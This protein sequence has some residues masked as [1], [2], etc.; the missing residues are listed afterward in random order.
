MQEKLIIYLDAADVL[1]P[2]WALLGADNQVLASAVHDDA[3]NVSKH[4]I[5][6]E[7]WVLIPA[8]DV[9]LLTAQLPKM[10]HS[11]LLQAL[12]Y[13]LEEQLVGELETLYFAPGEYQVNGKLPV[14][15][16]SREKL[17]QWQ[18]LL[19]SWAIE[20]DVILSSAFA[21]PYEEHTWHIAIDKMITVRTGLYQGFAADKENFETMLEFAFTA[22]DHVPQQ[23]LL[24]NYTQ[25]NFAAS[26]TP[27]CQTKEDFLSSDKMIVDM[28]KQV[29][30]SS[31]INLLHEGRA[32]KQSKLFL[33]NNAWKMTGYLAIAWVV[34]LF[35]YPTISYFILQSRLSVINHQIETIYQRNFPQ[36]SSMIAPK[37]RMEEKL[38]KLNNNGESKLFILLGYLGK[39]MKT[40]TNINFNRLE[41]QNN[42]LT[43]EL[44]AASSQD[45]STF[46]DFLTRQG[47][48]V[49]QQ[50]ANLA[51]SQIN[52][53]LLI[54]GG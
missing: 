10:S 44:T 50:N 31:G 6:K 12:P 18:S 53:T 38:S 14:A 45:F 54:E 30:L 5:N 46:T 27:L 3:E 19:K 43:L 2:S 16:V 40:S 51:G 22:S 37:L 21:L 29:I 41:F 7:I 42:Q 20:A 47:L 8:E 26:L 25:Q 52:A 35:L 34:L 48:T 23:L 24:H 13:A 33:R 1:H 39:D 9:L 17:Q 11:K 36:A 28:A 15:V 49:K 4:A 32:K